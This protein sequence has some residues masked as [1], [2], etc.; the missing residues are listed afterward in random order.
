MG[1]LVV[2]WVYLISGIGCLGVPWRCHTGVIGV[3]LVYHLGLGGDISLAC[4]AFGASLGALEVT[5]KCGCFG[6]VIG[7]LGGS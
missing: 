6:S 2:S 7:D 3:L 4:G 1:C 5:C